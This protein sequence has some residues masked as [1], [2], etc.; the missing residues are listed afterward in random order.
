MDS[1]AQQQS[2]A[3]FL[4]SVEILSVFTRD[5]LERL[6]VDQHVALLHVAGR[7]DPEVAALFERL[8]TEKLN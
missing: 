4:S 3:D 6:L 2:S 8:T 1:L 7:H 5:E